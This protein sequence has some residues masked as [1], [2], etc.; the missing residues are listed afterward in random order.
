MRCFVNNHWQFKMRSVA[1]AAPAVCG[2]LFDLRHWVLINRTEGVANSWITEP[3]HSWSSRTVAEWQ[4]AVSQTADG[5]VQAPASRIAD[6]HPSTE[7]CRI[8]RKRL[9]VASPQE[10]IPP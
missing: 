3:A 2:S 10:Y 6:A 1:S 9:A 8:D 4:P 5:S 7:L